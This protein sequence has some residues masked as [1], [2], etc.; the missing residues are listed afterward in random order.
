MEWHPLPRHTIQAGTEV[1]RHRFRP[2]GVST[3]YGINPDTLA[4][5]N[6]AIPATEAA[7]YA[8]DEFTVSTWLRTNVGL[9]AVAYQ[10]AGKTYSYTE[11]RFSLSVSPNS[12]LSLKF[13][14]SRMHQFVHLLSSNSVGLPN[15]IWVPATQRVPPQRSDQITVG[16]TYSLPNQLLSV[17]LEAYHKTLSGLIDYQTGTNFLTNFSRQWENTVE[18]NGIGDSKGV[19]LLVLKTQGRVTGWMAYTLARHRRRFPTIDQNRWYA[20]NYD[21][22][23]VFSLTG[24]YAISE[25]VSLAA[26][27]IYQSGQPTT[28]PIA[29]QEN[30]AGEATAYPPLIYGDRSN[31][32]M[33]AY[34]RLDLSLTIR[35]VTRRIRQAQWSFGVY[36]AYNQAN[37]FYLD[38][39]RR[40]VYAAPRQPV[41]FDYKVVRRAVFPVLPYVTYS[42]SF[43]R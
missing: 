20:P 34:H 25:Q 30:I 28:V 43:P 16:L 3:T 14:Y 27:W 39:D 24:Q 29:I 42:L 31:F 12:R 5:V 11:P 13:A 33:P 22:R 21:R 40:L 38:F 37:P 26:T 1:I 8:E 4:R 10:V 9:R 18:R 41:G 7:V 23:H 35:H 6:A 17:T 32:R 15:D 19:E 36:N 2:T